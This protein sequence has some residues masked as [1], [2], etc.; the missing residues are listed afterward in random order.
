MNKHVG[1][2]NPLEPSLLVGT[3]TRVVVDKSSQELATHPRVE[4]SV[5]NKFVPQKIYFRVVG[6]APVVARV[7]QED[8]DG[9]E[10]CKALEKPLKLPDGRACTG[11]TL[12]K[13]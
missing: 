2:L 12:N 13:T 6:R 4:D 10:S 3:T 9:K 1:S 11:C 8:L 7:P 5:Q